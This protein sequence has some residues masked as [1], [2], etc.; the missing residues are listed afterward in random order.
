MRLCD[1]LLS[2]S[3]PV[4]RRSTTLPSFVRNGRSTSQRY[5][6]VVVPLAV[7]MRVEFKRRLLATAMNALLTQCMPAPVSL[8]HT[9]AIAGIDCMTAVRIACACD[10]SHKLTKRS[11]SA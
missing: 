6:G 3:T 7:T 2:T 9:A 10:A 4:S 1:A 5:L 8:S 11:S